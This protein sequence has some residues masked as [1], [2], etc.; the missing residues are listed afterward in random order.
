[1]SKKVLSVVLALVSA[2]IVLVPLIAYATFFARST[3]II[4]SVA[5]GS[6]ATAETS[7]IALGTPIQEALEAGENASGQPGLFINPYIAG[8]IIGGVVVLVLLVLII[9]ALVRRSG[10]NKSNKETIVPYVQQPLI[11]E[12][13]APVVEEVEE[14][15]EVAAPQSEATTVLWSGDSGTDYLGTL[16]RRMNGQSIEINKDIFAIG[17]DEVNND[18][19]VT[20]NSAV[21]RKHAT[22]RHVGQDIVIEDNN[23]TNGTFVNGARV[24]KGQS[25]VI[26]DGDV[27]TLANEEFVYSA[28]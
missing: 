4:R 14:T 18:F 26:R 5:P 1:M 2:G 20:D 9:A 7:E 16:T 3:P 21:S 24:A 28:S 22:I 23:S 19:S 6:S 17:K 25:A 12:E 13:E 11:I 27:I 15:P 8:F 10:K